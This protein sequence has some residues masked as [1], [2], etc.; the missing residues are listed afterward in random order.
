MAPDGVTLIQARRDLDIQQALLTQ[1]RETFNRVELR[2]MIDFDLDRYADMG[3]SRFKVLRS[4]PGGM[5][6]H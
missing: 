6:G 5:T 1:T 4:R 2:G 3:Y